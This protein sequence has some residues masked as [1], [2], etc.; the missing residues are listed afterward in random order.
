MPKTPRPPRLSRRHF[1]AA[2]PTVV[3]VEAVSAPARSLPELAQ[4]WHGTRDLVRE[5]LLRWQ[6]LEKDILRRTGSLDYRK[7]AR[8]QDAAALEML[9]IDKRLPA[10]FERDETESAALAA[11]PCGAVADALAKLRAGIRIIGPEDTHPTG[12]ALLRDGYDRLA[13]ELGA[14]EAVRHG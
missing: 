13:R 7:A 10:L 3:A 14:P 11:L 2:A 12:W 8:D 1:L 5:L 9:A 4:A 6:D